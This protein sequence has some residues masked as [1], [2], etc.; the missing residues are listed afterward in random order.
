MN[1]NVLYKNDKIILN[2]IK[3]GKVLFKTPYVSY[4][5]H[6]KMPE[7]IGEEFALMDMD[8]GIKLIAKT[9]EEL[10]EQLIEEF[11]MLY[12]EY[13]LEKDSNLT[14]D[15][16]KL[17]LK[18]SEMF[19][20]K[21]KTPAP[22]ENYNYAEEYIKKPITIQAFHYKKGYTDWRDLQKFCPDMVGVNGQNNPIIKTLEGD[23]A[24]HDSCF[25]IKGVKGEFYP[26]Q[27]DIFYQSY[28][29]V[30]ST[31]SDIGET[32]FTS[33]Q[34]L[35]RLIDEVYLLI[36]KNIRQELFQAIRK[37]LDEL[38][39]IKNQVKDTNDY[40]GKEVEHMHQYEEWKSKQWNN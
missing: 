31:I 2:V 33:D 26:C 37:D 16:I 40:W 14:K 10:C 1:L 27:E 6:I 17:K 15:A 8:L 19:Y 20:I 7:P 3:D 18:L 21:D 12:D 4:I 24:L 11:N 38:K 22:N 5:H 25:V 34:A 13:V 39:R 35:Q 30:E 29:K 28:D 32:S 9:E 23:V 36:P